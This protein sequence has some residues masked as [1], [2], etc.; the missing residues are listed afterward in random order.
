[1][2]EVSNI[3]KHTVIMAKLMWV[4][5]LYKCQSALYGIQINDAA[6]GFATYQQITRHRLCGPDVSV[7]SAYLRRLDR[8]KSL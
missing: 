6:L 4:R 7:T 2:C 8:I 5:I 3:G 1:M